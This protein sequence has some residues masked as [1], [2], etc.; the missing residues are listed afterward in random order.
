MAF[1][2]PIVAVGGELRELQPGDTL[3]ATVSNAESFNFVNGEAAT[4]MVIGNVTYISSSGTVKLAR[5]NNLDNSKTVG[6][7]GATTIGVGASGAIFR[8]GILTATQTEWDT[9]NAEFPGGDPDGLTPNATYFLSDAVAGKITP[10]P[11]TNAGSVVVPI[12][13]AISSTEMMLDMFQF[14][15]VRS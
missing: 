1:K 10:N 15:V 13:V 8:S 11:P 3:L 2:K 4:T 12:G 5:A 9:V 6:L 14:R 7:V